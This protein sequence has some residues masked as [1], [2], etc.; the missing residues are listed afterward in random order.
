M[1]NLANAIRVYRGGGLSLIPINAQ[2]KRPYAR[3]LPTKGNTNGEPIQGKHGPERTWDPYQSRRASDDEVA[4]WLSHGIH[5]VAMVCGAISG[6]AEVIDFDTCGTADG[7]PIYGED[8]FAEWMA[9]CGSAKWQ[10]SR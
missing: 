10:G 4:E 6:S 7:G 2:T 8:T 5:A 9:A 3:L 1:T